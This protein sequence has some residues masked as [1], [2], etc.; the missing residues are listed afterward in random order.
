MAT[1]SR[2][3][4]YLIGYARTFEKGGEANEIIPKPPRWIGNKL[5]IVRLR[6]RQFRFSMLS[7]GFLEDGKRKLP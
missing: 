4:E 2:D 6:A 5:E 1:Y 3:L 7:T